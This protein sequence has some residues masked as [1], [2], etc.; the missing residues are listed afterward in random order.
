MMKDNRS[1]SIMIDGEWVSIGQIVTALLAERAERTKNPGVWDGAPEDA[2][3]CR[4]EFYSPKYAKYT[5]GNE[6][7]RELPKTRVREIAEKCAIDATICDN[8]VAKKYAADII[9]AAILEYAE[10]LK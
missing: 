10:G 6:Y 3:K 5:K 9:E 8:P 1:A 2:T 4:V 7:T